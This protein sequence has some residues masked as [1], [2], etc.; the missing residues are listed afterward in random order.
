LRKRRARK[1]VAQT[2]GQPGMRVRPF[3]Q[4]PRFTAQH[5][6]VHPLFPG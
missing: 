4:H 6:S 2:C 3:P 1:Y 5:R